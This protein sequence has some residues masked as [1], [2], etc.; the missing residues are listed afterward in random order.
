MCEQR[1]DRSFASSAVKLASSGAK[2]TKIEYYGNEEKEASV[3]CSKG[4][5][6]VFTVLRSWVRVKTCSLHIRTKPTQQRHLLRLPLASTMELWPTPN[7]Y[8][9]EFEIK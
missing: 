6:F 3:L 5:R 7:A 9:F 1:A 2:H 4:R 8:L